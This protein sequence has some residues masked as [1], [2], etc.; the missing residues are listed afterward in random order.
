[1]VWGSTSQESRTSTESSRQRYAST[2]AAVGSEFQINTY[3]IT[4]TAEARRGLHADGGFVVVWES[5][6]QD[7]GPFGGIFGQRY[8]SAGNAIGS[9]FHVNT[10]TI[11]RQWLAAVASD[12]SGNFVVVWESVQQDGGGSGIFGQRFASDGT[13]VGSEFQVNSYTQPD[14][15]R[16]S[17]S[18]ES[19]GDFTVVWGNSVDQD[20][21]GYGVFGQRYASSGAPIGTEFLI[22]TYTPGDQYMPAVAAQSDEGHFVV[23][24][25]GAPP[26]GAGDIFGQRF[27]PM[28]LCPPAPDAGCTTGFA[29]GLLIVKEL[30]GKEKVIAKLLNGP[31]TAQVDF[32]NPTIPAGTGYSLCVYDDASSLVAA[33][34]VA[35]AGDATCSGGAKE[36]WK[37]TGGAPPGGKGYKYKD[38]SL[39]ADG[40]LLM[41][42]KGGQ[43]G[44]A[45]IVVKGMGANL[46]LPIAGSLTSAG[47]VTVQLRGSNAPQCFSGTLADVKNQEADFFKAK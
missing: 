14:Q 45:K 13:P 25:R 31:A 1:M 37:A 40:L 46:P 47:S 5:T 20:G 35:R 30:A 12:G 41:L 4:C 18:V 15:L 10:Y 38:K 43:A 8:A 27:G 23:A 21:D 7:G 24:W 36:C 32:G 29:K 11:D 22:N 39:D 6:A 3:T 33:L 19:D 34:D 26:G 16:P 2:G 17:V 44:K 42:L 9:E 28:S